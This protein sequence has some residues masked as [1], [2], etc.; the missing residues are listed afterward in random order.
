VNFS[1]CVLSPKTTEKCCDKPILQ[2]VIKAHKEKME[3]AFAMLNKFVHN[4]L[5]ECSPS[6]KQMLLQ[7]GR[8]INI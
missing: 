6:L 2:R 7:P 1:F 5:L 4:A 8:T 3:S